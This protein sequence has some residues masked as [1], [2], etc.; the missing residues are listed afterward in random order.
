MTRGL[1]P[2]DIIAQIYRGLT[3]QEADVQYTSPISLKVKKARDVVV[4]R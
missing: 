2:Q 1:T 4:W 3:A